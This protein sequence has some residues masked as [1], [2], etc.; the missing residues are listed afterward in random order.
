MFGS[1]F[2]KTLLPLDISSA[3]S[4]SRHASKSSSNGT[5]D[6]GEIANAGGGPGEEI[7]ESE[8]FCCTGFVSKPRCKKC[9][10]FVLLLNI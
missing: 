6:K 9:L 2:L 1:K 8:Q 5:V 7:S 3:S 10:L 4:E